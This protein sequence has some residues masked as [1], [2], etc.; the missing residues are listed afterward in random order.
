[1][2]R[3]A[4]FLRRPRRLDD[5]L[6]FVLEHLALEDGYPQGDPLNGRES[7]DL[8]LDRRPWLVDLRFEAGSSGRKAERPSLESF[9]RVLRKNAPAQRVDP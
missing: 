7:H 9:K 4:L 5:S 3:S 1:M 2:L 8:V 6:S